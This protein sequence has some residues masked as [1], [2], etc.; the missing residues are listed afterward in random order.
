MR[1]IARI[2]FDELRIEDVADLA[3]VAKTTVYRRW[4]TKV[5][6]VV[7]AMRALHGASEPPDTGSV[8]EDVRALLEELGRGRDLTLK[9]ALAR[10]VVAAGADAELVRAM[11]ALREERMQKWHTVLARGVKRGELPRGVDVALV[12]EVLVAPFALRVLRGEPITPATIAALL[13]LVLAGAATAPRRRA[14]S[15]SATPDS[16]RPRAY[17]SRPSRA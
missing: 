10:A 13:E 15:P 16:P 2:G 17:R 4:P 5:E 14:T 1:E 6:L 9:R 11:L 8:R 12:A 3:G 7:D